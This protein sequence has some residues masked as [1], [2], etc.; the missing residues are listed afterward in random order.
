MVVASLRT[1]YERIAIIVTSQ[2]KVKDGHSLD[3]HDASQRFNESS[4]QELTMDG[5]RAFYTQ[6]DSVE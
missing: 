5:R 1:M 2:V 6:S 4:R 3:L